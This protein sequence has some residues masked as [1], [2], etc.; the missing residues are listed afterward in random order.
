MLGEHKTIYSKHEFHY[1]HYRKKHRLN[2]NLYDDTITKSA[3]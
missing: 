2:T 3:Q 1:E